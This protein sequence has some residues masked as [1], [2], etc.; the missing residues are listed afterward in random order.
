MLSAPQVQFSVLDRRPLLYMTDFCRKKG[1]KLVPYGVL[2][3]GYVSDKYVN[4]S[5]SQIRVDTASKAKYGTMLK[6]L[7]GWSVMQQLLS[8]LQRIARRKKVSVATVAERWVLQQP[9]VAALT[10]GARNARH[11]RDSQRLFT[12]ELDDT[13]MFD[14]DAVYEE[15]KQPTTDCGVWE[16]GGSWR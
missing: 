16:R 5:A 9:Q 14:I 10:I 8:V 12:F 6:Q 7:G 2:A 4:R 3:G 15:A 13:D 11:V 1:I